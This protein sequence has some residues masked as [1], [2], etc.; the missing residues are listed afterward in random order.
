MAD[1]FLDRPDTCGSSTREVR[2][3]LC[4]NWPLLSGITKPRLLLETPDVT[5]ATILW[6]QFPF[7][8]QTMKVLCDTKERDV[9]L[10]GCIQNL[11]CR[12]EILSSLLLVLNL[13]NASGWSRNEALNSTFKL[14]PQ[15][16]CSTEITC[17][18]WLIMEQVLCLALRC[19]W[20]STSALWSH[21]K[22][23]QQCHVQFPLQP[24]K[25]KTTFCILFFIPFYIPACLFLLFLIFMFCWFVTLSFLFCILV[26]WFYVYKPFYKAFQNTFYRKMLYFIT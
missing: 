22:T 7:L 26:Y 8:K 18:Y 19:C 17:V 20:K 10:C 14:A 4:W 21:M 6:A 1:W 16:H 15:T 9:L 24:H 23:L 25:M 13:R 3:W 2:L 5:E 12:L 11:W